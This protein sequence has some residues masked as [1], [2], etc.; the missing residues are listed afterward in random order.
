MWP[1]HWR[2]AGVTAR[3]RRSCRWLADAATAGLADGRRGV[4]K[5][6]G[7]CPVHAAVRRA[8]RV[9]PPALWPWAAC[10]VLA[11]ERPY[12]GYRARVALP[13]VGEADQPAQGYLHRRASG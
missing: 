1:G 5:T 3:M 11:A 8:T 7:S 6:H 4:V 9:V 12:P 10:R 13:G 2:D